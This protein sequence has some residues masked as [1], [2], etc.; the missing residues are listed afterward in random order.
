MARHPRG[1]LAVYSIGW[2]FVLFGLYSLYPWAVDRNITPVTNCPR[3]LLAG[4]GSAILGAIAIN[5]YGISKHRFE[6]ESRF[7]KWTMWYLM[8]PFMGIIVGIVTYALLKVISTGEPTTVA[9]VAAAF[10]FGMQ[11][12]R[13]MMLLE[14]AGNIVL[15]TKEETPKKK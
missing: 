13:F 4:M 12:Q 10:L 7:H 6:K 11:E 2:L 3:I 1:A 5:L 15:T 8:R 9:V 14:K